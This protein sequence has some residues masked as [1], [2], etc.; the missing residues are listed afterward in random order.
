MCEAGAMRVSTAALIGSSTILSVSSG[1]GRCNALT[2]SQV[3]EGCSAFYRRFRDTADI[4]W[5]AGPDNSVE[6]DAVDD[7]RSR[8]RMCQKGDR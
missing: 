5:L 3:S 2:L 7:A 6:N 4:R 8:H 1:N